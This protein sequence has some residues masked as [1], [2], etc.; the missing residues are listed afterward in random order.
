M[1]TEEKGKLIGQILQELKISAFANN[2]HGYCEGKTFFALAFKSDD[3]LIKTAKLA[4][5]L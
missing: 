3:E 1:T 2:D 5:V 4:G